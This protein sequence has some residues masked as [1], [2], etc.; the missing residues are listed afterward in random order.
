M[1]LNQKEIEQLIEKLRK[2]YREKAGKV[3]ARWFDI[4]P[5]E[6]RLSMA[7]KN[8]M[9]LEAFILA[10]ITN[11]EKLVERYDSKKKEKEHSFSQ[12][13]DRILE[14]QYARIKPYTPDHFHPLASLELTHFY[15]AVSDLAIN[16]IPVLWIILND[17][18]HKNMFIDLEDELNDLAMP[19]GNMPSKRIEDHAR[20]LSLRGISEIAIEKDKNDYIKETA[21]ALHKIIDFCEGLME[22]HDEDWKFP[23]PFNKLHVE[24]SRK[25][26]V[27]SLFAGLTGYGAILKVRDQCAQIIDDF[28]LKSFRK[29]DDNEHF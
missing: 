6:E 19:R 18:M 11:F 9:N 15:G 17:T 23:V 7:V 5:F 2:K 4:S 8:N 26:R 10:E 29:R 25:K 20:K 12:K 21:F 16:Y 28:R 27:Q 1:S 13:V 14:E 22:M 3:N 24:D